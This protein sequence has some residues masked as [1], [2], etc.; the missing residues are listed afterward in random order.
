VGGVFSVSLLWLISA[1]LIWQWLQQPQQWRSGAISALFLLAVA[2]G[3]WALQPVQ[4]TQPVATPELQVSLIQGNVSQDQKW[5]PVALRQD[6][7]RYQKL[8]AQHPDATLL[9]WPETAVAAFPEQL[10]PELDN[11]ARQLQQGQQGLLVGLPVW[12]EQGRYYNAVR[13]L[14]IASGEYRKQHLVPFGEYLPFA[15]LLQGVTEFFDLPMSGFSAGPRQQPLLSIEQDGFVWALGALICYEVAY[16]GLARRQAADAHVLVVLSNDAWFGRS[17][18]PAQHLQISRIRA[19]ENQRAMVRA[20]QNGISALIAP[21]GEIL[22]QTEQFVATT[23]S[24][25]VPAR[26]GQTPYQ[27]WGEWPLALIIGSLLLILG[28]Q[29]RQSKSGPR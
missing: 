14:G 23:L 17:W 25:S 6:F 28:W 10:Q 21:Q 20:T 15:T 5:D 11:F 27:R 2:A 19:I 1:A 13:G 18:A 24:G 7:N 26:Q 4:W 9:I 8:S 3:G 12:G 22:A 29:A 16:P